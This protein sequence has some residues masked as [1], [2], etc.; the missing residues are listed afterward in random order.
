MGA[1]VG[2]VPGLSVHVVGPAAGVIAQL[3]AKVLHPKGGFFEHLP[4][5]DNFPGRF[6]HL[7]QLKHKVPEAGLGNDPVRCKDE[8]VAEGQCVALRGGQAAPHHPVLSQCARGLH[9]VVSASAT[10]HKRLG[11]R[12]R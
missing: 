1:C 10:T 3:D 6:L 4:T 7:L 9:S 5:G 2:Y 11:S 8:H 12:F